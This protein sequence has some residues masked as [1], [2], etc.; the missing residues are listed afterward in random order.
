MKSFVFILLVTLTLISCSNNDNQTEP[1]ELNYEI[2]AQDIISG[3][4]L[5]FLDQQNLVIDDTITYN[6]LTNDMVIANALVTPDF[7]DVVIDFEEF[8]VLAF[9]DEVRNYGGYSIEILSIIEN[10]ENIVVDLDFQGAG[11]NAIVN[12]PY[13]IAKIDKTDKPIVFI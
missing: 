12:Q 3:N 10:E 1:T 8:T 5:E 4:G 7:Y 13:L 9:L 11:T 6:I 2:I